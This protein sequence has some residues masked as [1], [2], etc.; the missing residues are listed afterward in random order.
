MIS[1]GI[2]DLKNNLSRYIRRLGVA[3]RILV[4]D[5]GR[6]V[7]ELRLPEAVADREERRPRY[8]AL[9]RAGV[10]RPAAERG[11]PLENWPTRAE[12]LLPLGTAEAL[13]DE[14]RGDR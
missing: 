5:R 6:A 12:L 2:R 8:E 4:T 7:A 3:K 11:D 13:L 14:E 1:A 10:V 9:V